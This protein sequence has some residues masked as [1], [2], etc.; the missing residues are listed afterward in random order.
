MSGYRGKAWKWL[1]CGYVKNPVTRIKQR[2]AYSEGTQNVRLLGKSRE[3]SI[4]GKILISCYGGK[5]GEWV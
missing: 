3:I 4:V 5:L 2:N 1:Y